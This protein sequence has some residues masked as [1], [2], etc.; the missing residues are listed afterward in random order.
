MCVPYSIHACEDAAEA[1]GKEKPYVYNTAT[2][3]CFHY[4]EGKYVN[5]VYYSLGGSEAS[6]KTILSGPKFR[7]PGYDC[8][9]DGILY[10]IY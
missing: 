5:K 3:G 4:L 6:M 8:K 2:K 1:L 10:K 7:P 9:F